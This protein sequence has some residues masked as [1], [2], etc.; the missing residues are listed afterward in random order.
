MM[1]FTLTPAYGRDYKTQAD[2]EDCFNSN[3]DWILRD[4]RSPWDGKPINKEQCCIGST[5]VLRF[6]ADRK[7]TTV[8]V[9][10]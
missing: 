4:I 7:T 6:S 10:K 2:A 1:I 8:K 9:T 3:R 5:V